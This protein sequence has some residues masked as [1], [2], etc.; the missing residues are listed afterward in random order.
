MMCWR[1]GHQKRGHEAEPITEYKEVCWDCWFDKD[2]L[3]KRL[4]AWYKFED[5]L[6]YIERKAKEKKL[7]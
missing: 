3:E 2:T 5:N 7:I 6:S 4:K 1:C